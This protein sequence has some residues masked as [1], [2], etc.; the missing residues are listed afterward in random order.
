VIVSING[1]PINDYHD[2]FLTVSTVL[3]G[4]EARIE[5]LRGPTPTPRII[6][7]TL[8]KSAVA[9]KFIASRKPTPVRGLRVD[10]L[11]VLMQSLRQT[12]PD[13]IT[14]G[15]VIREVLAGSPA[16]AAQLKVNDV[17]THVKG[18]PVR[19]PA[20]FYKRMQTLTG[21]IDL[22]LANSYQ[23]NLN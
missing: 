15:V 8:D 17:I 1:T 4:N 9:G 3:A 10:Y 7:V 18:Q 14:H 6:T 11:S 5:V 22:T 19:T 2:L 21:P 13:G 16:A 20:E 12:K 23:V